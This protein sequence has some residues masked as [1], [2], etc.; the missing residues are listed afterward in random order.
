MQSIGK[1]QIRYLITLIPKIIIMEN[2]WPLLSYEQAK[3]TYDTLHMWTQVV[4]KIK[5]ASLPWI[6]HSWHVTL[7]I[8]PTGLTTLSLPYKEKNFQI[9]F[10]FITHQLK[11]STNNGETRQFDLHGLS[12]ADFYHK[13]M[14]FLRE[15]KIY[16]RIRTIPSEIENPVPFQFNVIPATYDDEQVTS[17]HQVLL[18]LQDVFTQF[19]SEFKG[20]CSPVH[21]FWGSFDVALSFFSG[22][23]APKHPGGIPGL[24]DWVAEEA[25]NKEVSSWG[26]W[27]GNEAFPEAAFYAYLYPEPEGYKVA[28]VK[29]KEAYY[30]KQMGEF[31]L[32]YASV[33]A[34]AS[35]KNKLLEFLH[36]TYRTGVFLAHWDWDSL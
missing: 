32:P 17:Y 30:H 23:P 24:P 22:A 33:Q 16:I 8:T 31:I 3:P 12:V 1:A 6:N 19:R 27:P 4:G 34:A 28:D 5:M 7:Y 25:Y 36:S 9:D 15:L 10:D 21:L 18:S 11:I 13:T 14:G 26:F 2:R 20:K 35:P 29:P